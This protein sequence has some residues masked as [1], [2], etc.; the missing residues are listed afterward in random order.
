MGEGRRAGVSKRSEQ[1]RTTARQRRCLRQE[2][3]AETQ[4]CLRPIYLHAHIP[5]ADCRSTHGIACGKAWNKCPPAV[6]GP[7]KV[8]PLGCNLPHAQDPPG[9]PN[10]PSSRQAVPCEGSSA[11]LWRPALRPPGGQAPQSNSVSASHRAA[12]SDSLRSPARREGW[13]IEDGRGIG[14]FDSQG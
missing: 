1:L 5:T 2:A 13:D 9:S 8:R 3:C 4:R 7:V 12:T 10:P 11:A 14:V 6:A